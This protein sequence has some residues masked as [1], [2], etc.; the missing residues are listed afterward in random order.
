MVFNAT[1]APQQLCVLTHAAT[2]HIIYALSETRR[3]VDEIPLLDEFCAC[4]Q[5]RDRKKPWNAFQGSVVG[6]A[7]HVLREARGRR[8]CR[9]CGCRSLF[10][11]RSPR[12]LRLWVLW[13]RCSCIVA[14][15]SRT[16]PAP[17][18]RRRARGRRL[19]RRPHTRTSFAWPSSLPPCI[20][21]RLGRLR[22]ALYQAAPV[23]R[24]SLISA[25][26]DYF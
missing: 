15:T 2:P 6:V 16:R 23:G 11:S 20:E 18:W 22:M 4:C 19:P 24:P 9:D 8:T 3:G 25:A 1:P 7:L 5:L 13:R 26:G 17:A 10:R 14:R 12:S 21:K